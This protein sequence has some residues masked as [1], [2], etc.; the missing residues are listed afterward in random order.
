MNSRTWFEQLR[1]T[2]NGERYKAWLFA[3]YPKKK[4]DTSNLHTG[5]LLMLRTFEPY[6][7][8]TLEEWAQVG[9]VVRDPSDRLRTAFQLPESQHLFLLIGDFDAADRSNV[10]LVDLPHYLQASR[11]LYG[12]DLLEVCRRLELPDR[13]ND[14]ETFPRLENWLLALKGRYYARP[15]EQ[16][17]TRIQ[18]Q[19]QQ[20]RNR[21]VFSTQLVTATY[22]AMGL[23]K[24]EDLPRYLKAAWLRKQLQ[25][26]WEMTRVRLQR[27]ASLG[28]GWRM[29]PDR[30]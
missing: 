30:Q 25:H 9:M 29:M 24:K 17:S 11:D 28:F 27:G 1:K 3:S 15:L 22:E 23:I 8:K 21:M 13:S 18:Q 10:R 16:L 26:G 4:I 2:F 12:N 7:E 6:G 20:L 5:D 19:A 14:Q